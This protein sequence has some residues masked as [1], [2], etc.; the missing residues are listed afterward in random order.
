MSDNVYIVNT[1]KPY[2]HGDL[3]RALVETGAEVLESEGIE[4][5]SLRSVA[6]LAGVSAMAP[7]RHFAD[8]AALLA[9]IAEHGFGMLHAQLAPAD[10]APD[11]REALVAQAV[12]YVRFALEHPDLFRLMYRTPPIWERPSGGELDAG[13]TAYG[14]F[15]RRIA[16]LFPPEEARLA[17]LSG[18]AFVHGLACLAADQ[19]IHPAPPDMLALTREV[20]DFLSRRLLRPQNGEAAGPRG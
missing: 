19:R 8:K 14:V 13:D 12:A 3:R 10:A 17:L 4:G 2:H 5:L 1:A 9:A 20:S 7:Y 11:P 18:W 15:A 6:R 16:T